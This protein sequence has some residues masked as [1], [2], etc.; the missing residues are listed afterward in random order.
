MPILTGTVRKAICD[1]NADSENRSL[2]AAALDIQYG[3]KEDGT[4][5]FDNPPVAMIPTKWADWVSLPVRDYDEV[6][7]S[8]LLKIR[9][10]TVV[11]SLGYRKMPLKKFRPSK[12]TVY[13]RDKGTCQYTGRKLSYSEATLDHVNPKSKGGKDTF[14]N[15]VLCAPDVNHKKGNKSNQEAGLKLLRKPIEPAP[16]PAAALITE[17]RTRDWSWF[18]M[19]T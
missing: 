16:V 2:V 18:L 12:R 5:D 3:L 4:W 15:L 1:M 11:V 10:P 14:T 17:A 9:V 19:K 7:N 8:A 6:I 13:Q